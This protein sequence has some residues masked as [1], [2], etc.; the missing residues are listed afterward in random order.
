MQTIKTG[1]AVEWR[2]G[3]SKA[4]GDVEQRFTRDVTRTIKG[5]TIKRKADRQEPAFLIRQKN[6][7]RVLKSQSEVE[8]TDE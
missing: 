1:N 3:R 5:K 2:W 8:K 4:E 7:A 6:G